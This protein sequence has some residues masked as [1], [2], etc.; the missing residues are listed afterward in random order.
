MMAKHSKRSKQ[1]NKQNILLVGSIILVFAIV[2][3]VVISGGPS[4]AQLVG[5]LPLEISVQ[6]AYAYRE[7]GAFILDVRT[8]Q[9]WD[10]GHIPG[11]TLIP[12]DQLPDRLDEVP[13]DVDI[14]VVCRSGNRSASGRDILLGAGFSA[15]TSMDGGVNAWQAQGLPFE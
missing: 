13:Q 10:A 11:A 3:F 1:D 4:D 2:L 6:D 14:V 9:E 5:D 7:E 12:L 8:Q 15:V